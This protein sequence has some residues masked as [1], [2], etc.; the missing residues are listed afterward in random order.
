M[1]L[2]NIDVSYR[3]EAPFQ[4]TNQPSSINRRPDPSPVSPTSKPKAA[5]PPAKPRSRPEKP[6]K[7][8]LVAENPPTPNRNAQVEVQ[9][10][11]PQP[12]KNQFVLENGAAI[13][14]NAQVQVQTPSLTPPSVSRNGTAV[15]VSSLPPSS[16]REEYQSFPDIDARVMSGGD[17][18]SRK[19]KREEADNDDLALR[20]S[21]DQQEKADAALH[22]LQTLTAQIFEAEDQ[23]HQSFEAQYS[24]IAPEY[25]VPESSSD[26]GGLILNPAIHAKLLSLLN[27]AVSSGRFSRVAVDD[28]ARLQKLEA[29]AAHGVE[30]TALSFGQDWSEDD[31]QEWGSRIESANNGLNGARVLLRTMT[32]GREEKQLYAEDHVQ[33]VLNGIKHVFD[34]ALIPT[35]ECRSSDSASSMF[36][37]SSKFRKELTR[38]M[39]TAGKLLSLLGDLLVKVDVAESVVTTVEYLAVGL[40]FVENA[41]TEKESALGVQTFETARR[42]AMDVLAR[43]FSRYSEQRSTIISEILSSLEKL[44]VTRQS[45]RQYKMPDCKPIQ[46]VSALLMRLIQTSATRSLKGKKKVDDEEE[47]HDDDGSGSDTEMSQDSPLKA[48]HGHDNP[49]EQESDPIQKLH[50]LADPLHDLAQKNASY[51]IGFMVQR[52]LTSTKTGDQPYRNLLDIFTEDFLSVLG[53]PDWPAA[54]LLLRALLSRLIHIHD[55]SKSPAPA[56]TMALDV[57]GTMG[58][59]ISDLKLSVRQSARALDASE[60]ELSARISEW[61]E[62]VLEGSANESKL[63]KFEGPFRVVLE[64]LQDRGADDPQLQSARGYLLSQWAKMLLAYFDTK[65]QDE[66]VPSKS[67]RLSRNLVSMISDA[68]WLEAR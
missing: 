63:L 43:I 11:I 38:L 2:Q 67:Q 18:M 51:L 46:L 1:V 66:E 58:S 60:S 40:I 44:P 27:K 30:N 55:D 49:A 62:T 59:G 6:A 65:F 68:S 41:A 22:G 25:F 47:G 8:Q 7:K 31:L 5:P 10:Q 21:V 36:A 3:C 61:A 23:I 9:I 33:A 56:R 45:A 15:I 48:K 32:A 20:L 42:K 28:V 19:R 4:R 12:V 14:R 13:N 17:P 35:V 53:S 54:E 34:M 24:T 39:V 52:A 64:Y 37:A 57:M 16:R 26:A 29:N 50:F